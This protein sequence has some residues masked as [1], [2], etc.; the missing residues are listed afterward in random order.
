MANLDSFLGGLKAGND[1]A[2]MGRS[3]RNRAMIGNLAP[4]IIGGDPQAFARAAAVDPAAAKDL[5]ASGE[6]LMQRTRGAA[7]YLESA[8]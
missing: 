4:S 5:Q 7:Q 8:L 2:E 1:I 3:Q 6:G